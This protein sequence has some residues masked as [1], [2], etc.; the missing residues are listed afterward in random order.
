MR[1]AIHMHAPKEHSPQGVT[2]AVAAAAINLAHPA[3]QSSQKM[4]T[5][6]RNATPPA[7]C[8]HRSSE[9]ASTEKHGFIG[10]VQ[11]RCML[12]ISNRQIS[13]RL[14]KK[15]SR[16]VAEAAGTR[17]RPRSDFPAI[18]RAQVHGPRGTVASRRY[19]HRHPVDTVVLRGL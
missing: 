19:T 15:S 14:K 3:S 10:P 1:V 8:R 7:H 16:G 13:T 2:M 12:L 4:L 18:L 9:L 6:S 11:C 5:R 17:S